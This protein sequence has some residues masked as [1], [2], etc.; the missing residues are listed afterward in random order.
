MISQNWNTRLDGPRFSGAR[1]PVDWIGSSKRDFLAFPDPVKDRMATALGVAQLRGKAPSAKPWKG[2][3]SGVLEMVESHRGNAYRAIYTVR[4]PD[5]VYVLHAFQKKSSTGVKT[6]R[7]DVELIEQR[8]RIAER[9]Y[10]DRHAK[11]KR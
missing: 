2:Q 4:Y 7:R 5:V 3:G 9:D 10:K 8:L 1:R 6:A 11:P